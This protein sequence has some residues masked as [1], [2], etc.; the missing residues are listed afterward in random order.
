MYEGLKKYPWDKWFARKRQFTLIT[1]KD[2]ECSASSMM[3]QFRKQSAERQI[4]VYVSIRRDGNL[5]VRIKHA[6]A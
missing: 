6:E 3:T 2:F 5:A 4:P 1:G